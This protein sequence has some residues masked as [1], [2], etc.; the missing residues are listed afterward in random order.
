MNIPLHDGA[1]SALSHADVKPHLTANEV[2]FAREHADRMVLFIVHSIEVTEREN[3][4]VEARGGTRQVF[5]PW[6]VDEGEL[7][8]INYR[9]SVPDG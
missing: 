4:D 5:M 1:S 9:Y 8:A 6:Y 7:A 2:E 3:V